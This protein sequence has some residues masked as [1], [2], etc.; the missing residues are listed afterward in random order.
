MILSESRPSFQIGL[1]G[2]H[3]RKLGRKADGAWRSVTATAML[4]ASTIT[5]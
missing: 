3:A 1:F 2:L 4:A 5:E